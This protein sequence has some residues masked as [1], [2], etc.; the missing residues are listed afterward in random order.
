M[1]IELRIN[2]ELYKKEVSPDRRLLDFLRDD[3]GFK[4]TKMGC[5]SGECGSCSIILNGKI[6]TS[7]LILL[8][9]LAPRSDIQTIEDSDPLILALQDSFIQNGAT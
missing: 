3:L 5:S 2:G 7:C 6:V 9:Q 8:S 1:R 4:G